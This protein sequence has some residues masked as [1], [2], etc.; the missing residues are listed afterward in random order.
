M[1]GRLISQHPGDVLTDDQA[2]HPDVPAEETVLHRQHPD[3]VST[4]GRNQRSE[5]RCPQCSRQHSDRG[6]SARSHSGHPDG[7]SVSIDA[8]NHV[9]S[10]R[11]RCPI[12]QSRHTLHRPEETRRSLGRRPLLGRVSRI[13]FLDRVKLRLETPDHTHAI[14]S[15][16]NVLVGFDRWKCAARQQVVL[17][18]RVHQAPSHHGEE[19]LL[20]SLHDLHHRD[21]FYRGVGPHP[22][23][24]VVAA[25]P[26]G[27]DAQAGQITEPVGYTGQGVL[28]PGPVVQPGTHHNLTVY[29]HAMIQQGPQPP[30]AGRSPPVAEHLGS[31]PGVGGVDAHV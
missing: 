6:V 4:N 24:S 12:A 13:P 22:G 19:P 21:G 30:E 28:Q 20:P 25:H 3:V 16:F 27:H 15:H 17:V 11:P 14:L 29:L 1:A 26:E 18:G 7:H 2:S 23:L 10:T 5:D 31:L 8:V 9:H